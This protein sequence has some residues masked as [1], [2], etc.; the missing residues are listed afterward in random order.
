MNAIDDRLSQVSRELSTL[1]PDLTKGKTCLENSCSDLCEHWKRL[2]EATSLY[3]L[4]GKSWNFDEH[5]GQQI[6]DPYI[7]DL[8]SEQLQYVVG[9]DLVHAGII[10]TYGYLFSQLETPYGLKRVRWTNR[11]LDWGFHFSDAVLF[12]SRSPEHC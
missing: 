4:W 12:L 7:L 8:L 10:H 2:K 6:V 9:T 3:L 5:A 1:K 11:K